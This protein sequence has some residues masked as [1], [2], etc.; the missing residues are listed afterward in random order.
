MAMDT[1]PKVDWEKVVFQRKISRCV[2]IGEVLAV[3][4]RTYH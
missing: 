4:A 2:C 1:A 3:S